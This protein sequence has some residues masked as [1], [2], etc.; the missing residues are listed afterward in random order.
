MS[1]EVLVTGATGTIGSHVVDALA[2]SAIPFRAGV[3]DPTEGEWPE[4]CEPIAFDFERP[5]TWGFAFEDVETLF[6]LRPPSVGRDRIVEAVDA[7]V[8]TGVGHVVYLSVLGAERNPLLPHRRIEKH[9]EASDAS[10]TFLRASYFMQNLSEIHAPEIRERDELFVPAGD[11]AL[12]FVDARDV[13][14]VAA[15]TMT[16]PG[17]ENR[18][19]DLTGPESLDF[20]SVAERFS[21]VLGRRVAY[22]RPSSFEFVRRTS[23]R[24]VPLRFAVLMVGIYAPA[25]LGLAG[26]VTDDVE[27]LLGRPPTSLATFVDDYRD[28]W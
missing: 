23:A 19:Y 27:R 16:E 17:H 4:N 5:E 2:D 3:R 26:R 7:A 13:G 8:R 18:A 15:V 9:L 11:G 12:S 28:V 25:R 20:E 24:G 10:H 1:D 14:A 6:L 21:D 22:A